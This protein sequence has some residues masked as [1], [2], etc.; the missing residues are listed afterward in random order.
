MSHTEVELA[1]L[2]QRARICELLREHLTDDMIDF[3]DTQLSKSD[4]YV[5][6]KN[7]YDVD[8]HSSLNQL[9]HLYKHR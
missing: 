4:A 8:E 5:I 9:T 1:T 6:I 3:I 7:Y 2:S